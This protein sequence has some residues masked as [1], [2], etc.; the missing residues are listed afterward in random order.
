LPR[1]RIRTQSAAARRCACA[2]A[3]SC[4]RSARAPGRGWA[5]RR[6]G[7]RRRRAP[8][9]RSR[10]TPSPRG[11]SRP[12]QRAFAASAL[13]EVRE[14]GLPLAELPLG[15]LPRQ[16]VGFANARGQEV[17]AAGDRFQ[18]LLAEAVPAALRVVAEARP[19]SFN[20]VP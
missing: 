13:Y 11:H 7:R 16:A 8:S 6:A 18:L 19:V 15:F 20:P 3:R 1:A 14:L 17:A 9:G 10:G 12:A 4:A 2:R 5:R